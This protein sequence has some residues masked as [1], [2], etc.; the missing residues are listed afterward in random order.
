MH[1]HFPSVVVERNVTRSG[2]WLRSVVVDVVNPGWKWLS[3][4]TAFGMPRYV[5]AAPSAE[6]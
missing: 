1:S 4:Y 2:P 5:P 6:L 3:G